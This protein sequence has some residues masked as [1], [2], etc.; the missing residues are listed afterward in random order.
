MKTLERMEMFR[1]SEIGKKGKKDQ[2]LAKTTRIKQ[3]N[4]KKIFCC[5]AFI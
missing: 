4:S 1:E 3:K 2:K 5:L